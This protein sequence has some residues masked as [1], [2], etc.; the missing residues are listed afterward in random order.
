MHEEL[1]G[2]DAEVE[3]AEKDGWETASEDSDGSG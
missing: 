3:G 1:H 2:E